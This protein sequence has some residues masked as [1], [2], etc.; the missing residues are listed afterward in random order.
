MVLVLNG[1]EA[2]KVSFA[3]SWLESLEAFKNLQ[4][5]ALVLL[6][7]EQCENAWLWPFLRGDGGP[8]D[9]VFLVYDSMSVDN[10]VIH[11]WPL[12]VAT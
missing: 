12:G 8:V 4:Q 5:V 2:A 3:V 10:V 7:N 1:R 6:G 9:M 11:Q